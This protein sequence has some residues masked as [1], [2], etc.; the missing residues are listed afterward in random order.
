MSD[1][2]FVV[3][4]SWQRGLPNIDNDNRT[5]WEGLREHKLLLWRCEECGEWYWPKAFCR[6]HKVGPFAEHMGWQEGSG[7]GTI[8]TANRHHW[9]FSPKFSDDIPYVYAVIELDE[10]PMISSTILNAPTEGDVT[11]LIG[12]K[13]QVVFEDHPDD[14]FTLPRFELLPEA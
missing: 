4:E 10:G 13:C 9:A 12:R 7:R 6:N 8:F 2:S 5:F 14:G 1:R 3:E 11:E